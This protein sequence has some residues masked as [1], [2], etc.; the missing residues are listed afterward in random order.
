MESAD[1]LALIDG[2]YLIG[3]DVNFFFMLVK[4]SASFLSAFS[5]SLSSESRKTIYLP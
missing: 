3:Y 1:R 2:Y 4:K 5:V